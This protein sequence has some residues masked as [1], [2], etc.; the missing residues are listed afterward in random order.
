MLL[1]RLLRYRHQGARGN[2]HCLRSHWLANSV[3]ISLAGIMDACEMTWNRLATNHALI[4]S[5]MRS[6]DSGAARARVL[7]A[8]ENQVCTGL[9]AGGR[10]IRTFSFLT[11]PLPLS[12]QQSRLP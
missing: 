9:T 2:W 3:F 10:W 4:R 8:P 12:R 7:A 11:D 5:L 1:P 6:I